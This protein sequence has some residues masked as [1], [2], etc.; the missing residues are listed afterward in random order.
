MITVAFATDAQPS[1]WSPADP[2]V[3]PALWPVSEWRT[4]SKDAQAGFVTGYWTAMYASYMLL[5]G[6]MDL[7][8]YL[9]FSGETISLSSFE[10]RNQYDRWEAAHGPRSYFLDG[11]MKE[12][13]ERSGLRFPRP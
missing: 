10:L 9:S 4:W 1:P 13:I 3:D 2:S 12:P 5:Q 8:S 7:D 11:F 6:G